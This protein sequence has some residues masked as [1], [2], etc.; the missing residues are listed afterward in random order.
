MILI[1]EKLNSLGIN[2]PKPPKPAG[3]YIPISKSNNLIFVSGQ[4]PIDTE[5][6]QLKYKGKIG[7]EKTVVHG[8][9]AAILCTLNA[10]AL[11]KES[12]GSLDEVKK[13]VKVSGFINCDNEFSEHPKVINPASELLVKIF[14][15]NG[16]HARVAVGVSSLPLN[17]SVEMEFIVEI[18][19]LNNS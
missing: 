17:S 18:A 14:G 15:E 19:N 9:N 12:I 10:I 5:S 16:K 13:I 8:Q 6:D 11:I 4:I 1:E 3:S 2:L 7:S